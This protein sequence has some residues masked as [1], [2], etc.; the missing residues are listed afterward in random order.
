VN[1]E[2]ES[3]MSLQRVAIAVV[4]AT[5]MTGSTLALAQASGAKKPL[6]KMTCEDFLG[7]EDNIKPKMVYWAVAYGKGGKP[8]S[9]VFDVDATEKVIPVLIEEY[10]KE[11]FWQKMKAEF[12][13]LE[14][15]M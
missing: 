9:A 13:K 6:G 1:P 3:T 14:K 8:Q 10:K 12:K 11:S 7:V 15:K 2:K 4:V 5:L